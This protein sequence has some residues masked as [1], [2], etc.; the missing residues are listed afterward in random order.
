MQTVWLIYLGMR[1]TRVL[2]VPL[3]DDVTKA[4]YKC[5]CNFSKNK[6]YI[7]TWTLTVR[8]TKQDTIHTKPSF[9]SILMT[10]NTVTSSILEKWEY[11]WLI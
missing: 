7:G 2:C 6:C 4:T 8:P 10:E 11:T 1:I 5:W 3:A 9:V